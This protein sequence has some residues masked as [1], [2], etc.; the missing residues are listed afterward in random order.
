MASSWGIGNEGER[1]TELVLLHPKENAEGDPVAVFNYLMKDWREG[2]AR[3][4]SGVH[5]DNTIGSRV[6]L[7]QK[8][9]QLD[10]RKKYFTRRVVK[11]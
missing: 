8:T 5:S 2:K 7:Q 4:F 11:H 3:F 10:I 6:R 1:L 9:F